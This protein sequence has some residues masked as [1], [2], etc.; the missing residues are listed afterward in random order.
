MCVCA[1]VETVNWTCQDESWEH[2]AT[3]LESVTFEQLECL[4]QVKDVA[5]TSV[6]NQNTLPRILRITASIWQRCY[7]QLQQPHTHTHTLKLNHTLS[8]TAPYC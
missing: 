7:Y 3:D 1:G 4:R 5:S 6:E 8:R 2:Q